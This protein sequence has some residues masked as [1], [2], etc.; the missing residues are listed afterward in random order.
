MAETTF[1]APDLAGFLGLDG[2]GLVATG[3]RITPDEVLV[4]CRLRA[5]EE[6]AF[7]RACGAQG[8]AVGTVTQHLA[9][10]PVSWRP[11][12]LVV[13]LRRWRCGAG[14]Y[15]RRPRGRPTPRLPGRWVT[16][17]KWWGRFLQRRL[18]GL[19]DESRPGRP[20]VISV[21]QVDAGAPESVPTG[22]T[23]W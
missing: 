20:P 17:R 12:H 5:L 13:R 15:W 3:R 7:C 21:E 22:A 19:V 11:T 6:D 8:V 4:E 14:S 10:V 9:Y 1:T 16:V 23:H 18:D 2:L